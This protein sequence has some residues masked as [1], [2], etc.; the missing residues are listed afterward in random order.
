ME[1]INANVT[2]DRPCA[3]EYGGIRISG[4]NEE[5]GV[6]IKNMHTLMT[7][8]ISLNYVSKATEKSFYLGVVYSLIH[9]LSSFF[10]IAALE[11][12]WT[13]LSAFPLFILAF[14][15]IPLSIT[16]HKLYSITSQFV[17]SE[18]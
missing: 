6:K 14:L 15:R 16:E 18:W 5:V 1:Y 12:G 4:W 8:K 10:G 7:V 9:H 11:S 2:A 13:E 3:L 17:L